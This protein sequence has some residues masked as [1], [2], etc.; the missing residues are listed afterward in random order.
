MKRRPRPSSPVSKAVARARLNNATR[1]MRIQV[2][3]LEEGESCA[4]VC[5]T[6]HMIFSVVAAAAALHPEYGASH[7]DVRK[8]RGA[9][10]ACEQMAAADSFQRVNV[11]SLDNAMEAVLKMNAQLDPEVVLALWAAMQKG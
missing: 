3:L 8:L 2:H 5:G 11:V 9:A 1:D 7:V 10:S 6:L 4:A